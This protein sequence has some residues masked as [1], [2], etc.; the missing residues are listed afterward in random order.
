MRNHPAHASPRRDLRNRRAP[1]RPICSKPDPIRWSESGRTPLIA[2]GQGRDASDLHDHAE[3][4]LG[5]VLILLM[6]VGLVG[7]AVLLPYAA[8]WLA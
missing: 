3:V 6:V 5:W 8:G 7:M 2:G 1:V 4:M